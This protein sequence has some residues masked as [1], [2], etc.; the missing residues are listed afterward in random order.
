MSSPKALTEHLRYISRDSATREED[1]GRVF[2]SDTDDVDRDGFAHATKDDR[3]HFRFIVSPEDGSEMAD[4]KPFVRDLVS[5]MEKD[6]GTRLEWVGAVHDN[7]DHPHAHIVIR[8]RRDDGR[9]LVIPKAYISHGVRSRAEELVTLE[10]GPQTKL[11]KDLK[12]ARQT[13][14][15]RLTDIDRTLARLRSTDG[16]INLTKTPIRYRAL[17][18][19]RLRT[20]QSFGLAHYVAHQSWQIAEGFDTTLK[21]LGE[22][23]DIIKQMNKAL[24]GQSGRTLDPTRPFK[25]M[26]QH[27][28]KTGIVLQT[29]MR[30]EGHDE[31]YIIL[32]GLDGRVISL[33]IDQKNRPED[34]RR[35]MI[36]EARPPNVTPKP[37]DKTVAEIADKNGGIYSVSL[38]QAA[39][40]SSSPTYITAHF[41]RLEA[42]RRA[43]LVNRRDDATW[44]IPPD[45]LAR[46]QSFQE[47]RAL[48]A[49][50]NIRTLAWGNL[51]SQINAPGLTWLDEAP[52]STSP[53]YGFGND[54]R[55]AHK[56]RK[57]VL[58]DRGII[59]K[60]HQKLDANSRTI[61]RQAGLD[62]AGEEVAQRLAK[63]YE[64][65]AGGRNVE[66]IYRETIVRPDGKFAII[67][68]Q[69][70][71]TI[72]PW[73]KVMDRSLGR[74]ISGVVRGH[75]ISW[76]LGKSKSIGI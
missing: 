28:P 63:P 13:G 20:L 27:L 14:A 57:Q 3:H 39:D 26:D 43:G 15:E 73:R 7:T 23:R 64:P 21:E 58:L 30:G 44:Q 10:L 51:E 52:V 9:D 65:L 53:A 42:M 32:D 46:V 16:H 74:Q 61:L 55:Q 31:A 37:A 76:N 24:R 60:L 72:V 4:L 67:E 50:A 12:I 2:D 68:R 56:A 70:S 36:I 47:R 62:A 25:A 6:L 49:G 8:G 41:R 33:A 54:V 22:R 34:L 40:P 45:Y 59:S 75:S 5:I 71:F 69:R 66:G 35:G 17:N 1:H 29:G 18:A 19:S 38:H 48:T 11:E